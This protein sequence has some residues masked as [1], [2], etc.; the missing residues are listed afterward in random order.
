[1]NTKWLEKALEDR[2]ISQNMLKTE[3]R[4]SPDTLKAWANGQPAR[5]FTL[6]KLATAMGM[7]YATLRKNLGVTV[8]TRARILRQQRAAKG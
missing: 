3:F 1:M 2:G 8:L 4:I 7:D 5:P 6:R